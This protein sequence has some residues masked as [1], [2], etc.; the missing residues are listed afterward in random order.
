MSEA[1]VS[2]ARTH[3]ATCPRAKP[4][5]TPMADVA[6]K[7]STGLLGRW[8]SPAEWVAEA[9][10]T[11][12]SVSAA[13][14]LTRLSP[15]RVFRTR[16]GSRAAPDGHGRHGVRRGDDGGQHERH[17]QRD[18]GDGQARDEPDDGRRHDDEDDAEVGDGAPAA[19]EAGEGE[20]LRRGEQQRGQDDG[21][22]DLRRQLHAGTPGRTRPPPRRRPAAAGAAS[23]A[24]RRRSS[25]RGRRR[26]RRGAGRTPAQ[27][28]PCR[29]WTRVRG[30]SST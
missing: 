19:H 6:R 24:G 10:V 7:N 18:P 27:C 13:A 16:D 5:A 12:N 4:T 11:E 3:A 29:P 15:L 1:S 14:S 21:E 26:R 8:W 25:G 28:R 23:R 9:T 2:R 22:D 20:V 17:R 30:G